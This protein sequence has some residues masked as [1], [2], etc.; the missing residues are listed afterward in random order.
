MEIHT[1]TVEVKE[2]GSCGQDHESLKFTSPD[3]GD[4]YVVCP[5]TD[6]RVCVS[7]EELPGAYGVSQ[8]V[9]S[10]ANYCT[11]LGHQVN[12]LGRAVS[13]SLQEEATEDS[14]DVE[15][16]VARAKAGRLTH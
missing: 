9:E 6:T 12:D 16:G 8:A 7:E 10:L 1:L 13:T 15:Y 14:I 5:K 3:E 2:C 4:C 11:H